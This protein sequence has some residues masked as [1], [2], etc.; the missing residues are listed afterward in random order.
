MSF[1]VKKTMSTCFTVLR[2]LR[3]FRCSVTGDALVLSRLDYGNATLA[4]IPQHILRQLQSLINTAARLVY[5]SSRFD[6][7]TPLL[8][9]LHRLKAKE[10]IDFILAVLV[11]KCVHGSDTFF[12]KLKPSLLKSLCGLPTSK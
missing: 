5:S 2:Q 4:G 6:H 7:I 11:F 9:Q 3:S 10:W 12:R 1:H 8:R